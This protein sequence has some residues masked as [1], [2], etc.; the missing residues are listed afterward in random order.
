MQGELPPMQPWDQTWQRSRCRRQPAL[1]P[2]SL[3]HRR[4]LP[5][6]PLLRP[7]RH[8][9]RHLFQVHS[10]ASFSSASWLLD[11]ALSFTCHLYRG[12]EQRHGWW[13][14]L[15]AAVLEQRRFCHP[16]LLFAA[17][18]DFTGQSSMM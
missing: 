9:H 11:I 10:L 14:Y 13:R 16:W 4:R 7:G 5:G 2:K 6:R 3:P 15:G 12:S 8:R 1:H 18:T 17:V